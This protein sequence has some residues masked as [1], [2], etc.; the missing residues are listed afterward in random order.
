MGS[1]MFARLKDHFI[2]HEGNNQRPH[3]LRAETMRVV[4]GLAIVFEVLAFVLPTFS[5]LTLV[6]GN[7][8]SVL[9]TVLG[10]STTTV[11]TSTGGQVLGAENFKFLID[12]RFGTRGS[13]IVELQNRLKKEGFFTFP[14]ST[15]FFGVSTC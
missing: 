1:I 8:A 9:P 7:L 10:A 14:T 3:F 6:N 15:G 12:L 4:A 2:P 11:T 13:E 5:Y